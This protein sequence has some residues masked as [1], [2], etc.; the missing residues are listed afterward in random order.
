[1]AG[2]RRESRAQQQLTKQEPCIEITSARGKRIRK[3]MCAGSAQEQEQ[4]EGVRRD[5][6]RERT[7]V[8]HTGKD[9]RLYKKSS[10]K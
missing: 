9:N 5:E 2:G 4:E 10:I 6:E 8:Q 3:N 7:R 1:V